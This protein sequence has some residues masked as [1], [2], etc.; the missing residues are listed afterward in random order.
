MDQQEE[1]QVRGSI[2]F[3]DLAQELIE[4]VKKDRSFHGQARQNKQLEDIHKYLGP[5]LEARRCQILTSTLKTC[6]N[7]H[8]DG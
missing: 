3:E 1:C 7:R 4:E 8:Q 6:P 5:T 2:A